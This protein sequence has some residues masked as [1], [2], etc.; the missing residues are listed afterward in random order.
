[1]RERDGGSHALDCLSSSCCAKQAA[2]YKLKSL[3]T[4]LA[5][6]L[7]E[8]RCET[9]KEDHSGSLARE[10]ANKGKSILLC[11]CH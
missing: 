2:D 5:A 6:N 4:S 1:M 10:K 3:T 7:R 11:M 9:N 8:E